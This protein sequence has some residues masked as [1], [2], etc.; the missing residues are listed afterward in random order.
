[1]GANNL[2]LAGLPLPARRWSP[3]NSIKFFV[4]CHSLLQLSQLLVSGY[5]KSSIS[6]IE[7]RYGLS[8]Q[9]SG[10]L[11]AFNEV[12]NTVLI[13]FVS[14][15]GSRVHRPRFIGGGALLA[16]LA[17]L[18][19]AVPHFLSGPYEYTDSISSSIDNTSTVCQSENNLNTKPENQSCSQQD[20]P[21]QHVVYPL[22]LLGQLLLGIGAVPIQ[23]FGI[24]Y[25]DDHASKKNSP[26]YLDSGPLP[27]AWESEGS[28]QDLG[29]S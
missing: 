3:F 17:S 26:L 4:L 8:S 18:L 24:S 12:G 11:A 29:C 2:N 1:M 13:V 9:K 14:F 5:M 15:F 6:T 25:I 27:E 28:A 19:M 7:R 22:L 10:V 20:N 16:C 23:P 21:T